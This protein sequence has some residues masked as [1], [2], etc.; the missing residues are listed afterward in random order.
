MHQVIILIILCC[1]L[2]GLLIY[3]VLWLRNCKDEDLL[4]NK[5]TYGQFQASCIQMLLRSTSTAFCVP[6][7]DITVEEGQSDWYFHWVSVNFQDWIV[8][9][10]INWNRKIC[11]VTCMYERDDHE[12][13]IKKFKL[14]II[15]HTIDEAHLIKLFDKTNKAVYKFAFP[16]LKAKATAIMSDAYKLANASSITDDQVFE[17]MYDAW[18]RLP[19]QNKRDAQTFISITAFLLRHHRD[20]IVNKIKIEKQKRDH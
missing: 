19:F 14:R 10:A 18:K 13:F 3:G 7:E 20:E 16:T 15:H 11:K 5:E 1:I 8:F 12:M 2:V 6:A 9:F 4:A 17:I